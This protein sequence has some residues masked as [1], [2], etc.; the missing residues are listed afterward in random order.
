[1]LDY[2]VGQR[3]HSC[4]NEINKTYKFVI[5]TVCLTFICLCLLNK[6][7]NYEVVCPNDISLPNHQRT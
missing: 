7:H 4:N 5:E 3:F 6:H 1:M 2:N